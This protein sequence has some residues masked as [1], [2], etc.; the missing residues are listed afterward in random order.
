MK[1]IRQSNP[2]AGPLRWREATSSFAL[3][4]SAA[5]LVAACFLTAGYAGVTRAAPP[6]E[7][8]VNATTLWGRETNKLQAGLYYEGSLGRSSF[9]PETKFVPGI[10]SLSGKEMDFLWIPPE[11]ERYRVSLLDERG[12]PVQRTAKGQSVGRPIRKHPVLKRRGGEYKPLWFAPSSPP[13]FFQTFKPSDFFVIS[14]PGKYKFEWEMKLLY[15]NSA[16]NFQTIVL[17]PVTL[18]I[19]VDQPAPAK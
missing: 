1:R 14:Q 8:D 13:Y 7:P 5:L 15:H 19:V 6:V 9:G 11:T 4:G 18:D 12:R 2:V 17:P 3:L 16:T 10:R